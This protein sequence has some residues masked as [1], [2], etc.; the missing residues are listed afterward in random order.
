MA[1][2]NQAKKILEPPRLA[3]G[4]T[5][6]QAQKPNH[7]PVTLL[8]DG[9]ITPT[10]EQFDKMK[11]ELDARNADF[12]RVEGLMTSLAEQN[13]KLVLKINRQSKVLARFGVSDSSPVEPH[14]A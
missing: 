5:L 14:P 10:F 4:N 8:A 13:Q 2:K 3:G 6:K 9:R 1:P 7:T 11:S 12:F